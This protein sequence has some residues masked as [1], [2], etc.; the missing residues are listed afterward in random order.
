M[1]PGPPSV[2]GAF[3]LGAA[4]AASALTLEIV[5][6]W[7][8]GMMLSGA[9]PQAWVYPAIVASAV[10]LAAIVW[11]AAAVVYLA[12]IVMVGGP[13]WF[14]LH[15]AR[16]PTRAAAILAGFLASGAGGMLLAWHVAWS[17][18]V[19]IP[20]GIAGAV[21]HRAAYG[22]PINPRPPSP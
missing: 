6:L 15:Q 11:V 8:S 16:V 4:A 20:G 14:I 10:S 18:G 19:A 9:G 22:R 21:I 7:L 5:V 13:I 12:G 1:T 2:A 17:L 3:L